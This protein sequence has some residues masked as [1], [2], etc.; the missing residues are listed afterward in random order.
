MSELAKKPVR[1]TKKDFESDQDVRWCPG[2][3][4]YAILA[5]VQR[6]MAQLGVK[7][8]N[9]VFVS[10]IG[11]SSRFPYYMNT[12]GFHTIHGRA[13]AI[14]SGLKLARPELDVWVITGDGD[15]LSI[16]GNHL[17]H[18]LRRNQDL[19]ILLFN[20]QIYGLTK[21]QYSPTSALSTR[22][23]STP[24]GSIDHP[25]NPISIALASGATFVARVADTDAKTMLGIL[26]R[27]YS[28]KGAVFI[29]LLQNCPVFN[30]GIWEPIKDD[31]A[32]K[33]IMLQEGKP[34]L[35]GGGKL[36]V[37]LGVDLN[38]EVVEVGDGPGQTPESALLVHR[39]V[40]SVNY[41]H[42]L[43]GMTHPLFP[44]PMG[45]VYRAEKPTYGDMAHAQIAEAQAKQG[46]GDIQKLLY[47]GMTWEVGADGVKH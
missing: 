27:A 9:T 1:L 14:A 5:T 35:F 36:G 38:P 3:G 12:Y 46:K 20:N 15:G 6:A 25:I 18:A 17:M 26:E 28:H 33:Q 29:E 21:G 45:V 37:K 23:A 16:G 19:K 32:N 31:P 43:A 41:A 2:C 40:G 39:E 11:C 44:M 47:S 22:S 10:G 13:P 4:D 30:D 24:S 7:R 34:L 42:V 8:E